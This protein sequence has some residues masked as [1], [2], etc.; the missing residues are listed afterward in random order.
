MGQ[1]L[2]EVEDAIVIPLFIYGLSNKMGVEFKRNW[3]SDSQKYPIH[4]MLGAPIDLSRFA[5]QPN[6]YETHLAIAQACME[7]IKDIGTQHRQK[8]NPQ[9]NA[10]QSTT[11]QET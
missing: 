4:L 9:L 6:T 3:G 10:T 8:Y 7:A 11:L 5:N 1:V 2:C